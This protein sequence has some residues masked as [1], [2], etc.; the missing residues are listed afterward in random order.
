MGPQVRQVRQL[1]IVESLLAMDYH[2]MTL[3]GHELPENVNAIGLIS[4][5]FTDLG[6]P[7]I[8]GRGLL[9]SDA[10]EGQDPQAARRKQ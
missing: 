6:V 2:A 9:P 3:T 10:V 5:G 8:A 1:G 4:N 7:P